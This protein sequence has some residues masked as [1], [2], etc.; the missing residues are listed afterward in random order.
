MDVKQVFQNLDEVI[1]RFAIG[2]LQDIPDHGVNF[3]LKCITFQ[4]YLREMA[5]DEEYYF[6]ES[7]LA[8]L[9]DDDGFIKLYLL[10]QLFAG[11]IVFVFEIVSL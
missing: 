7:C 9:P 11:E 1:S 10:R 2:C 3:Q 5:A 8:P 6:L 4:S